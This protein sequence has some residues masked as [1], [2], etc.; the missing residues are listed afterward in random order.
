M[1]SKRRDL[2]RFCYVV[3]DLLSRYIYFNLLSENQRW[4]YPFFYRL[5]FTIIQ[6]GWGLFNTEQELA[7]V[8]DGSND[9]VISNVNTDFKVSIHCQ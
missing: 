2:I 9:W 8:I 4:Y 6:D 3:F 7:T 1:S 5:D